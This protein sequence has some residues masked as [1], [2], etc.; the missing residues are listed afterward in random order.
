MIKLTTEELI[1]LG[2]TKLAE[3]VCSIAY[4]ELHGLPKCASDN[5]WNKEIMRW[6]VLNSLDNCLGQRARAEIVFPLLTE[7]P[8]DDPVNTFPMSYF[9][10]DISGLNPSDP[11]ELYYLTGV[12]PPPIVNEFTIQDV[13]DAINNPQVGGGY[14]AIVTD[15]RTIVIYSPIGAKYNDMYY[16]ML[17]TGSDDGTGHT[18][19]GNIQVRFSGGKDAPCPPNQKTIDCF[20]SVLNS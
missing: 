13:A 4:N 19:Q 17:W 5:T 8:E 1:E 2:E 18:L 7:E 10:I 20:Y 12:A 14:E 15:V 16:D 3:N 9:L 6:M 11:I